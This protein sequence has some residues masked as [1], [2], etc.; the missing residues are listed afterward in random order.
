M[1]EADDTVHDK[2]G[3]KSGGA[4]QFIK[5]TRE[6]LNRVSFPSWEDVRNTTVIVIVNVIFFAIFLFLIDQGWTHML[7]GLEWLVNKAAGI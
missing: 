4:G 1:S 3:E 2:D 6:E 5:E 7:Q